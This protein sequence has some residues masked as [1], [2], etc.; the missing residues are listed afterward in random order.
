[1]TNDPSTDASTPDADAAAGGDP[2]PS[3]VR[4]WLKRIAL[5]AGG[6]VLLLGL[7]I[8]VALFI[9]QEPT[10]PGAPGPEAEALA[11]R[12][13]QAV[14]LKAWERTGAVKWSFNGRHQHLWDRTRRL[15]RVSWGPNVVL[16]RLDDQSGRAW[17]DAKEA[18][19]HQRDRLLQFAWAFWCNDSFWLNPLAKLRDTGTTRALVKREDGSEA[20]LVQYGAGGVTPGDRYLWLV[21]AD[22]LP[23]RY[24]MW[25]KI[26]PVGGV[27]ATWEAW[28]TL[29]TGAK[30]STEHQLLGGL[31]L[32]LSDVAGA[33]TLQELAPGDDPFAPL[34]K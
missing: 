34:L 21:N 15:A 22:A 31:T 4:T 5:G 13:E 32:R 26:L 6:L 19:S 16:L 30:I 11:D 18:E 3:L 9:E 1:M 7:V 10:P 24:K 12:I 20:L 17:V 8:V 29:A 33:A 27:D 28:I 25:V 23:T 2:P 14:N